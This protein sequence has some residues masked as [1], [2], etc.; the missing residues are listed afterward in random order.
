MTD[1]LPEVKL[2]LNPQSYLQLPVCY[3]SVSALPEKAISLGAS[4]DKPSAIGRSDPQTPLFPSP[5]GGLAE[6]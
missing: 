3:V 4:V 5:E 6:K 2:Y 1:L